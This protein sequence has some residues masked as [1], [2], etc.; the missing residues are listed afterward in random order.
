MLAR[1]HDMAVLVDDFE[2]VNQHP[3]G[4]PPGIIALV[5]DRETDMDRIANKNRADK[6]NAVVAIRKRDWI[7]L[8]GRH[9]GT[10]AENQ[11]TVGNALA[12]LIALGPL[13]V[14][15]MW[16]KVSGLSGMGDNVALGNRPAPKVSRDVPTSYSSK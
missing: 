11:R 10:N 15:M 8:R 14:N 9:S 12:K 5:F 2:Q 1:Q 3:V 7:D 16:E 4:G 6:T 13:G